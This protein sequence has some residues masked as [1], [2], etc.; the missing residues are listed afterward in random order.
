MAHL[1]FLPRFFLN[2]VGGWQ[3]EN[4]RQQLGEFP[5]DGNESRLG[6]DG[7]GLFEMKRHIVQSRLF[8]IHEIEI[9]LDHPSFFLCRQKG[10]VGSALYLVG[11]YVEQFQGIVIHEHDA[12]AAIGNNDRGGQLFQN[13]DRLQEA[14]R[15]PGSVGT[16]ND[17]SHA[18]HHERPEADIDGHEAFSS[19]GILKE[20]K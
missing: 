16:E 3:P 10:E 8:G 15:N 1:G 7:D 12:A 5:V 9:P 2:P 6:F 17:G 20:E 18:S 11:L 14:F 4:S 19:K 13:F